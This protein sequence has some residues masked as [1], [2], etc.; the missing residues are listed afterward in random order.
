MIWWLSGFD[1]AATSERMEKHLRASLI[2]RV[3]SAESFLP[4]NG[5][6]SGPRW[7][8]QL[9]LIRHTWLAM[10]SIKAAMRW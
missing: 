3:A 7:H 5:S 4:V 2:E 1:W 6:V 9:R 8:W 10:G